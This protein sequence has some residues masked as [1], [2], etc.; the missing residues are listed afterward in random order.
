MGRER[1][2]GR[3]EEIKE[4]GGATVQAIDLPVPQI[5]L[6]KRVLGAGRG[7]GSWTLMATATVQKC[8]S[9]LEHL[10]NVGVLYLS[11]PPP[12]DFR[13]ATNRSIYCSFIRLIHFFKYLY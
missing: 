5:C 3:I 8:E 11:I 6:M 10:Q 12:K 9:Q 4:T 1:T 2:D 13:Y 7:R